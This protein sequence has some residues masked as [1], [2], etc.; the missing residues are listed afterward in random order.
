MTTDLLVMRYCGVVTISRET[1]GK[2]QIGRSGQAT[3]A[4]GSAAARWQ[5]PARRGPLGRCTAANGVPLARGASPRRFLRHAFR[6]GG[7]YAPKRT[8][9][10]TCVEGFVALAK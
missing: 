10:E 8:F 5:E 7:C 4:C 1:H 3:R 2:E 9:L 6:R